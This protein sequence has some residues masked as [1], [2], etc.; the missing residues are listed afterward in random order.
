MSCRLGSVRAGSGGWQLNGIVYWRTGLPVTV[1]QTGTDAVD[2]RST[3]GPTGSAT[4]A[5]AQVRRSSSGSTPPRSSRTAD[6]GYL[7]HRG[8]R[9]ILRGPGQFNVDLS[10]A[11]LTR[12]RARRVPSCGSRRSTC[13]IT[14]SSPSP[15]PSSATPGFG[16]ITEWPCART[17]LVP[18]WQGTARSE[19]RP[20]ASC[21][22]QICDASA[23]HADPLAP[24]IGSAPTR[25]W[26]PSARAAWARCTRPATPASSG[27]SPSRSRRSRSTERFRNEALAIAALNHPHI[28]AL[29]DVG[30]DYLVMEYV[31]GKR[32]QGPL[33][34]DEALRLAATDRRRPR[35][36]PQPRH[37]PPRPQAVEHPA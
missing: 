36:R 33:P 15:T 6:H 2:G 22:C 1:T 34:V 29:F 26:A 7:R 17:P 35:A 18:A 12:L 28:C 14:R 10:L 9:N 3:T 16:R 20:R 21:G 19:V 25:S 8:A 30:P 24:A 11:K 27:P 37:R 23:S 4:G 31:E 32:L 13:S 5:A